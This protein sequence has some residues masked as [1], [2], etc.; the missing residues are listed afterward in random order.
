MKKSAACLAILLAAAPALSLRAAD[1]T[2]G[3]TIGSGLLAPSGQTLFVDNAAV[4]GGDSD[5]PNWVAEVKNLWQPGDL[6]SLTG[7]AFAMPGGSNTASGTMTFTFYDLGGDDTFGGAANETNHGSASATLNWP[8]TAGAYYVNFDSPLT[9][10]AGSTGIAVHVQNSAALRVKVN[11]TGLAPG[12]VRRVLTTGVAVGGTNPNFR[13]S[14]AGTVAASLTW[15]G[16][17]GN[18]WD[19]IALNWNGG[20]APYADGQPV[21]FNDSAVSASPATINLAAAHQP[22]AVSVLNDQLEYA[23]TGS[24]LAGPA[25]LAKGGP[26]VLGLL[27]PNLHSGGTSVAGGRLRAGDD[28]APGSGTLTLAGGTLSSDGPTARGFANPL[29]VSANSGL[30]H[31]D[32]NGPLTFSG[33]VDFGGAARSLAVASDVVLEGTLGNGGLM[34][35]SGLGTLTLRGDGSQTAGNWQIGAG[36]LVVDGAA[37]S[38][39]VGGIRLACQVP[40]GTSR[41][42]VINGAV[43][44]APAG[45]NA[46]VGSGDAF[47]GNASATNILEITGAGSALLIG[48]I[49]PM[50][51]SGIAATL[52]VADGATL[53][54]FAITNGGAAVKTVNLDNA[55]LEAVADSPAFLQ[56]M[57]TT[58]LLAGGAT[59]DTAGF[60]ITIA[61]A[62]DG[63]GGL[64][65]TG[66]GT[67]TLGGANSFA[68][69]LAVDEGVLLVNG[70]QSGAAGAVTV[71]AGAALG[72]TGTVGGHTTYQGGAAA[73]FTKDPAAADSPLH[74]S[75]DLTLSDTGVTVDIPGEIPLGN[76]TYLLAVVAGGL[77]GAPAALPQLTGAGLIASATAAIEVAGGEIRLVVSG[78]TADPYDAW[79]G[80][81]GFNLAGGKFDD[82]DGDGSPNALEFLLNGDPTDPADKGLLAPLVQDASAPAGDEFTLVA[83]IRRGALFA[84]AGS[85]QSATIG[86]IVCTVTGGATP[87]AAAGTVTHAGA[88]DTAP[89]ATGLP[90]LAETA[91]EYH[92]FSLDAA[93]G[94]G[95]R[96]FLRIEAAQAP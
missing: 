23:F 74:F 22:F 90:S 86:G 26:G 48:G 39:T 71:A 44:T 87:G 25:V 65:K 2:T 5:N 69:P 33:A 32:D 67:L 53:A 13:M 43:V 91:W 77:S 24:P 1:L 52:T 92:T 56:G 85:A 93:A 62:M 89:A 49:V 63:A 37:I 46:R 51:G 8:G 28:G 60:A 68:G 84:P 61:Q 9:F 19:A 14:L 42:R 82:D 70:D 38:R 55:T 75:G 45:S 54:T 79:A 36:D 12:V 3:Y 20:N 59:I 27:S 83:A 50:G 94:L 47:I 34:T 6:V 31:A 35:K 57:N 41:L 17:A 64:A 10:L 88:S 15:H 4:G 29:L 16:G 95:G 58:T 96:G 11:T 72:G 81:G 18:D 78:G 76:G 40:D 30:G 80:P 7:I 73:R 21:I 66:T